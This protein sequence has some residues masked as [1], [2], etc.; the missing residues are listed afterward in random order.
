MKKTIGKGF[1]ME[2]LDLLKF[3]NKELDDIKINLRLCDKDLKNNL[4]TLNEKIT[5]LKDYS[6]NTGKKVIIEKILNRI[7]K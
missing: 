4:I 3:L 5:I 7:E 1:N 2:N 6:Y